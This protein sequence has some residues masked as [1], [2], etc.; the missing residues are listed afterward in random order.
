MSSQPIWPLKISQPLI[1]NDASCDPTGMIPFSYVTRSNDL[2]FH[3]LEFSQRPFRQP[4]FDLEVQFYW[5]TDRKVCETGSDTLID[6]A[7]R[8]EP[9]PPKLFIFHMSRCG[10]TLM[11]K[12]AGMLPKNI[13]ISEAEVLSGLLRHEHGH[14]GDGLPLFTSTI[15]AMGQRALGCEESLIIKFPSW[16]TL[17]LPIINKVY[18]H[19]PKIFLYREPTEV[20]VS[21]MKDPGQGWIWS[22]EL[23][24]NSLEHMSENSS[25]LLNCAEALKL[26]CEAFI[27]NYDEN[28][29]FIVNYNQLSDEVI[30][31]VFQSSGLGFS[32][33]ELA[34]MFKAR[35]SDSKRG[36]PFK[37]DS[38]TKRQSATPAIQR[39]AEAVLANV[40][41]QLEA[42]RRF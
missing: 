31:K 32:S 30:A 28:N 39:V 9:V 38:A 3:W 14:P 8:I 19:V 5:L 24:G 2:R 34:E 15:A 29:C 42:L 18:S 1:S 36:G 23:V 26:T 12:M 21:N 16:A 10:S 17:A 4:F 41:E 27:N 11:S 20:L 37:P 35:D 40:Y 25:A 7:K 6:L 13:V 22:P 33:G